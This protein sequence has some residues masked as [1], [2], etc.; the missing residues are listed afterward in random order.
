MR[1]AADFRDVAIQP[2]EIGN[3]FVTPVH[4]DHRHFPIGIQESSAEQL[5]SAG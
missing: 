5:T 1:Q 2:E 3:L 4:Y